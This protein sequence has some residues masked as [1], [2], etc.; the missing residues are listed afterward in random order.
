[1]F[2]GI[3]SPALDLWENSS[4]LSTPLREELRKVKEK[5]S[6]PTER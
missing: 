2:F 5:S 4:K 6:I 1:M 3:F